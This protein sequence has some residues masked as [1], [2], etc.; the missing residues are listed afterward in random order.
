MAGYIGA[1]S[2]T[3]NT[4]VATAQDVT[5]T[6]TTPEVTII[7]NTHEDSDSGREGKVIFKGQQSG[8]EESTLAEIEAHHHGSSDDEQGSLVFRTNDGSDGAS[9]TEAMRITSG[10]RLGLGENDPDTNFHIDATSSGNFTEAMR[11]SNTGGGANEGNYIQWEIANTS[12]HGP[13]IGGRREGTGGTGLHFYTGEINGAPTEKAR[14]DH[15]GNLLVG[16]T[17]PFS[18]ISNGGAGVSAMANGQLFCGMA[19]TPLYANREDSDGD[20]AVFRKDGSAVGTIGCS[21]GNNLYISGTATNHAG[22]TFATQS[23]LPTTQGT[24]NNDTVDLGQNGN[25][26]DDVYATNTSIQTSDQNEKQQIASLTDAEIT[27]AKALSKLFKTFKWNSAVTTKGDNA[28]THT[29]VIAQQI[30]TAMSDAG[31]DAGKYAFFISGTWWETQTE[32]AAVEADEEN[33]IEAKDA[34]TRTDTYQTKEEAPEGATERNRKGIRYPELLSFIGAATEQR[35][36]SI[37]SRLTAL[38]G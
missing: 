9:P 33:G 6:D 14:L 17:D 30:E 1:R 25:A 12:G 38:E 21:G 24:A 16:H 19:G 36:T 37:E 7:N 5:A 8:G 22:L 15:D 23:I 13:R 2:V 20:I 26:F 29:G 3:L 18:P 32:V 27:A 34:Y 28:R 10:Q 4:T 35:L 11:I 31:L